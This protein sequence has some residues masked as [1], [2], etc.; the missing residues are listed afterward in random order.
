MIRTNY[1]DA[2]R[3]S[4]EWSNQI[5][6]ALFKSGLPYTDCIGDGATRNFVEKQMTMHDIKTVLFYG[7]GEPDGWQ[8]TGQDRFAIFDHTNIHLLKDKL[9]YAVACYS[10]KNLGRLT[11][12]TGTGC[13]IGYEGEFRFSSISKDDTMACANSG[14]LKMISNGCTGI[15]ALNAIRKTLKEK[16]SIMRDRIF[17][18]DFQPLLIYSH[19][20]RLHCFLV[21]HGNVDKTLHSA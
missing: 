18:S 17:G 2:T 9:I 4:Y 7:H 10:G 12:S 14:V 13:F 3:I 5:K 16:M 21:I 11:T 8:L 19:L 1:D 20:L 6:L 15:Q